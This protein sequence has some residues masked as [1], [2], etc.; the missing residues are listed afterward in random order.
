MMKKEMVWGALG[1][2][3]SIFLGACG[4]KAFT[5]GK[6]VD[7]NQITMLSDRFNEN[8]MQLMVKKLVNSLSKDH[9][10]ASLEQ[11]PV[12]AIGRVSNRTSDHVDMKQLTD[13]IR[14]ELIQDRRLRFID[15]DARAALQ[16]EYDYN[17]QSGNVNQ[18]TVTGPSQ[19]AVQYL[20]TG[21]LGSYVQTVGNDKLVYYKLTLNLTD[22]QTNEIVWSDDKE[23]KKQ[24]EKQTIG[25]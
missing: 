6:Y 25:I 16:E 8:D 13:Q 7:P 5:Q 3:V 24:F 10:I 11:R 1:V 17:K 20:I 9:Y 4:P 19:I 18:S 2:L 12:V 22:T 21:D 14:T 23:V 15:V